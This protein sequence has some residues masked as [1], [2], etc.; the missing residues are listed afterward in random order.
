MMAETDQGFE[1]DQGTATTTS[2]PQLLFG[3]DD[4][5][6]SLDLGQSFN[7][8][9]SSFPA[10]EKTPKMLCF[11][12]QQTDA[13]IV[14]GESAAST[15]KT[16][17][18]PQ[19]SGVTCS[20]SS[21]A[22]SGNNNKSVKTPSKST[23]KRD[24]GRESVEC[25]GAIVTA[26]PVSQRTNKKSK[27]ENPATSTGHAK[28]RKEKVGDRITALQQLVSPFGKIRH[29]YSMKRWV[30]SGSCTTSGEAEGL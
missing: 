26:Q 6:V 27:V 28:A 25:T 17:T 7:Y 8:T 16:A 13:E 12:G 19:R 2:F 24:R 29:R 9:Y 1:G 3:G 15:T 5:V 20:D 23:R 4:D 14:F 18:T 11:G 30:I 21:S 22:S 10:H